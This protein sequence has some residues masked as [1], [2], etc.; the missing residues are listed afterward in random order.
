MRQTWA[1]RSPGSLSFSI[2][3]RVQEILKKLVDWNKTSFGNVKNRIHHYHTRIAILKQDLQEGM[4][5]KFREEMR[6]RAELNK[7][8]EAE[9]LLW[10]QKARQ[11]WLV[12][13]DQN[14]SYFHTVVKKRRIVNRIL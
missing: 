3:I 2:A 12:S 8:L 14:T 9:E 11:L 5:D 10:A 4:V 6:L 1:D 13:G 7:W